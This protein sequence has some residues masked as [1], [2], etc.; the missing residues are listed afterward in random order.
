MVT[1]PPWRNSD[2]STTMR[3]QWTFGASGRKTGL[4]VPPNI[5]KRGARNCVLILG[6]VGITVW[7]FANNDNFFW[8]CFWP[9]CADPDD[10]QQVAFRISLLLGNIELD[11]THRAISNIAHVA[12]RV[13]H[14][15]SRSC[16]HTGR[17]RLHFATNM[18]AQC[19]RESR[20][21]WVC[22][23]CPTIQDRSG[24]PHAGTGMQRLAI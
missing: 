20:R 11:L 14:P 13:A 6:T 19:A 2:K 12:Y 3:S 15:V 9:W 4:N 21:T 5:C 17:H 23:W 18:D 8:E 22:R 24:Q 10:M 16:A 1:V 7:S